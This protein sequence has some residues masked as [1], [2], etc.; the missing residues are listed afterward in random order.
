MRIVVVAPRYSPLVGGTET[1]VKEVGTRMA[2]L[3]HHVTVLTTNLDGTLP[4]YEGIDGVHVHRV[5]A[6]P[7]D[8]D[9]Y[10]SPAIYREVSHAQCDIIHFQGYH[11]FVPIIGMMA[12]IRHHIPYVLTFH[13]GGHSS[14]LRNSGRGLQHRL[15][16]PL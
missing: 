14:H 13:S 10:F 8:R 9:Y 1:H 3:G 6:W 5:K 12:A 7:R 16:S 15:L 4:T 11:N 2:A